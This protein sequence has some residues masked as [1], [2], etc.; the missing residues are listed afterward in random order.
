MRN[1]LASVWGRR[2][3][4]FLLY[5]TDGIPFGF[6]ADRYGVSWQLALD[7]PREWQGSL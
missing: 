3:A 2:I 4:F 6:T 7:L 1:L 5:M